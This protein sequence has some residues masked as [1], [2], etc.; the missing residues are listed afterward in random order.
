MRTCARHTITHPD[1]TPLESC[2]QPCLFLVL[3]SI[4]FPGSFHFFHPFVPSV[5][6]SPSSFIEFFY[7]KLFYYLNGLVSN[8]SA[9]HFWLTVTEIPSLDRELAIQLF[10]SS[11]FNV[12]VENRNIIN[13]PILQMYTNCIIS[14]WQRCR[15]PNVAERCAL[16]LRSGA[17]V[18]D[19]RGEC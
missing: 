18:G 12:W 8:P 9:I 6:C 14:A 15:Q 2:L 5:F 1:M 11:F 17:S 13:C 19:P 7:F 16:C 10:N 4:P 3:P